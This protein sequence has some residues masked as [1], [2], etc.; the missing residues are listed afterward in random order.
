MSST[1]L[2]Q[3]AF[4]GPVEIGLRCLAILN[5]AFP[6]VYSLQQLVIFDYLTVHSDDVPDGPTGLHPQ[7]PN[8]G[9]ELLVRRETLQHGLMLYQSRGLLERRFENRGLFFVATD[10]SGSFLDALDA[11][12]IRG[13]R[14]RASWVV[15][16]FGAFSEDDL[17]AFVHE[18]IGIWGA[19]FE[20]T[21][22]LW[23]EDA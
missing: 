7:T 12:Y 22:V 11:L 10:R 5:E 20:W 14:Q 2:H 15:E 21:A 13:L 17:N 1:S 8:R 16:R 23:A 3:L 4:N 19:E 6:A 18:H 9:G